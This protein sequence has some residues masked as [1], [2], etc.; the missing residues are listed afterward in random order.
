MV[1]ILANMKQSRFDTPDAVAAKL[2][3][4][5][6]YSKEKCCMTSHCAGDKHPLASGVQTLFVNASV[7]G[8][9][10]LPVQWPWL[11]DIELPKANH[12][13]SKFLGS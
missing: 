11:V 5:E 12:K 2:K 3:K 13:P 8:T 6:Q 4:N 1:E 9:E 7:A 10:D